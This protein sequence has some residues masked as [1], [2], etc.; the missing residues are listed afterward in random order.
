[1]P[2]KVSFT[3]STAAGKSIAS[4]T[5]RDLKRLTL[6]LGGNDAAILL[7]DVDLRSAVPHITGLSFFNSGQACA[8]PKRIYV[9]DDR[10][11]EAV[12][13]F[14][15]AASAIKVGAPGDESTGMGPLSTAPQFDRVRGLT[16]DALALGAE[17]VTGGTAIDRPGYFYEPTILAGVREGMAIVDEEQFGPVLPILRYSDV[18]DAV[19]RANDT[20]FG[21]CGSVW[22]TDLDHARDV[23]GQLECGN[24]FVNTHGALLPHVP[25]SG[26]KWSG[27][28][29][30]NGLDGLLAFTEP[31]VVHTARS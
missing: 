25:Y 16:A 9:S 22:S 14:A 26:T 3:G 15:A 29:V 27:I 21:L 13:A 30:E 11:H 10:Y 2:R 7:P 4:V 6:E 24:V 18:D 19:Q 12:E 5:G 1:V 20:M 17:A 23:A 8:L 28:G 31:Q